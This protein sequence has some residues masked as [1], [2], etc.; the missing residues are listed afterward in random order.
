MAKQRK[1]W[2]STGSRAGK[3]AITDALKAEVERKANELIE[4]TL[5]SKHVVPPP[6]NP[7]FNYIIGLSTRWHS[8]NFYFVATYACPGPNAISPTFEVN[9]A[10]LE[11]TALGR[12]NLAFMRHTEKW[13]ELSTDQ[14]LDECLISI[15]DDPWF[16]P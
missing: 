8:R 3:T 9:F 12:F 16:Q 15:R 13:Q 11:C 1:T 7:R 10:R 4:K 6:E 14:T 5:R 2:G